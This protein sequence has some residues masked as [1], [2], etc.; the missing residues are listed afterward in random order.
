MPEYWTTGRLPHVSGTR[1]KH[2]DPDCPRLGQANSVR[3]LYDGEADDMPTC[4]WCADAIE[5]PDRLDFSYQRA[6][7]AAAEEGR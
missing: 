4:Q 6:L 5:Q 7:K 3:A 1:R 2:T